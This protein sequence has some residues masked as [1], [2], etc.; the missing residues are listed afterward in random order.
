M[1][2]A[3]NGDRGSLLALLSDKELWEPNG[4]V[5]VIT[6]GE[7]TNRLILFSIRSQR[8]VNGRK[9]S[10]PHWKK[11]PWIPISWRMSMPRTSSGSMELCG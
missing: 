4:R 2:T 9:S 1:T 6:Q 10:A 11:V 7:Y 5:G 3:G 8:L